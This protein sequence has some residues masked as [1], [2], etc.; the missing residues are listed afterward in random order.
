MRQWFRQAR[1]RHGTKVAL[2]GCTRVAHF[3]NN[4][5][6]FGYAC[7]AFRRRM[8]WG[9]L[10]CQLKRCREE[11][12]TLFSSNCMLGAGFDRVRG[13]AYEEKFVMGFK[14][15]FN[16]KNFKQA[17]RVLDDGVDSFAAYETFYAL[18]RAVG[19]EVPGSFPPYRMKMTLDHLVDARA[20]EPRH[21]SKWPVS[22]S[23]GTGKKVKELFGS[24]SSSC[25]ALSD[26]LGELVHRLRVAGWLA[27]SDHHGIVGAALCWDGRLSNSRYDRTTSQCEKELRDLSRLGVSLEYVTPW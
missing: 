24:S 2:P 7:S 3:G 11:T 18:L 14:R 12:G 5:R 21:V 19:Q 27:A 16:N 17:A 26:M 9:S 25:E 4:V 22:P 6:T 23:A 13:R 15:M 10:R 20:I 8:L 1:Q